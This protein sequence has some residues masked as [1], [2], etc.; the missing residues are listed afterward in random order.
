MRSRILILAL[1][2]LLL[3][4][5]LLAQEGWSGLEEPIVADRPDFTEGT[6][7]IPPGHVQVEGGTTLTR[8]EDDDITTFGELLVRIGAGERWEGRIGVPSYNRIDALQ[9]EISGLDDSSLGIKFRFTDPAGD[10]APGQPAAALVLETSIPTGDDELTDDEWV[11]TAI[12]ALDWEVG[13]RFGLGANVGYSYATD[14]E[15]QFHQLLASLS[16]GFSITDRLGTYL[17]WYGLS[18]ETADGP[19]TH[20]VDGG[21]SFL[22]NDDL[23]VDARVGTGLNDADPDWYVGVGGSV[24][25]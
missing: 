1:S 20:Y 19:T 2:G 5:A 13:E 18:E 22:I 25:W 24:R 21:L 7:L 17:E 3:G 11:P 12:L 14:E 8:V 4:T 16:G 10:L 15:E 9:Q 6:G 23:V